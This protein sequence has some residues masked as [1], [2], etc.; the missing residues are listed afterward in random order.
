MKVE[1][2]Q[3]WSAGMLKADNRR[4]HSSWDHSKDSS[5][6]KQKQ[7]ARARARARAREERKREKEQITPNKTL[8]AKAFN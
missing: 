8:D 6:R 3:Q 4:E 2:A 5:K 7:K 1:G